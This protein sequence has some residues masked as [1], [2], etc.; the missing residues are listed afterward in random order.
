MTNS[1]KLITAMLVVAATAGPA[2]AA[3][4][5]PPNQGTRDFDTNRAAPINLP[6]ATALATPKVD[7]GAASRGPLDADALADS[8]VTVS[9]NRDGSTDETPVS[10]TLRAILDRMAGSPGR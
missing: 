8:Y 3:T 6:A 10:D 5:S 1:A 9:L 2:L 7:P 4:V